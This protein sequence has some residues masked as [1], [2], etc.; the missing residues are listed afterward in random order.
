MRPAISGNRPNNARTVVVLPMPLRPMQRQRFAF[1]EVEI[2]AVQHLRVAVTRF[3]R[4][5]A[6]HHASASSPR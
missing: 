3:D 1:A 4:L 6:E 2:D 5:D